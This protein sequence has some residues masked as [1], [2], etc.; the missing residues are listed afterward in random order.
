MS[1]TSEVL[2]VVTAVLPDALGLIRDLIGRHGNNVPA[3]KTEIARIRDHGKAWEAADERGRAE[4]DQM[5]KA[6]G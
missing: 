4:L 1:K 6:G 2:D 5:R 3:I